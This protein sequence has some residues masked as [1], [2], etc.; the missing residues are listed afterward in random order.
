MTTILIPQPP[1]APTV[2]V[3]EGDGYITLNWAEV[4][5][6]QASENYSQAGFKFEGYKVYQLPTLLLAL[7]ME[8]SLQS[9]TFLMVLKLLVNPL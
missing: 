3:F 5:A 4:A 6:Y 8:P 1:P 7:L 9:M 2:S